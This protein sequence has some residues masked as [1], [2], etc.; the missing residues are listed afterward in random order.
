MSDR[1]VSRVSVADRVLGR[2]HN[3]GGLHHRMAFPIDDT[4]C[5]AFDLNQGFDLVTDSRPKLLL[6]GV[7]Q[8]AFLQHL[9]RVQDV[10]SG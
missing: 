4:L 5:S 2:E 7:L 3:M 10:H 1:R 9:A 8:E 6:L